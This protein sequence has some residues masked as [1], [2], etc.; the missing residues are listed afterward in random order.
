LVQHRD[1]ADPDN[2]ANFTVKKYMRT[3]QDI[4]DGR[5]RTGPVTLQ[6][7]NPDYQP[8]IIEQDPDEAASEIKVIAEL[9]EVLG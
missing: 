8:L 7:L 6:P 9:I 3:P 1:I 2:D 4:S 5:E